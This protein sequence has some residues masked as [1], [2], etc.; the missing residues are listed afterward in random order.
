MC[1]YKFGEEVSTRNTVGVQMFEEKRDEPAAALNTSSLYQRLDS[2]TC[3]TENI[4]E[5]WL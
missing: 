5:V 1:R 3:I 2:H 4:S